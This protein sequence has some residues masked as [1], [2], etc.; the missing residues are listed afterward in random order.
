MPTPR[1][2]LEANVVNGKIYLIGSRTGG[3][4]FTVGLNEAYDPA[5]D[6]WTTKVPIPYP[7]V[8]YASAV[9]ADKIYIIGGQDEY[10]YPMNLDIVQIYNPVTDTWRFGAPMPNVVWQAA[11]GVTS[12]VW[13]PKR[14]Y[15]FAG[16]PEK[17]YHFRY[18]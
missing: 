3:Q 11:A 9:V 14:I 1:T 18:I 13:T 12:N 6:S 10:A 2:Q 15:V 5:T 7:V 4:Y 8:Q 16:V 17:R